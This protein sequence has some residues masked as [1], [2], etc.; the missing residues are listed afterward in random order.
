M[1]GTSVA[2]NQK[3]KRALLAY[4]AL[5]Q[6]LSTPGVGIADAL[7]PF[8]AEACA[9][10][11]GQLFDAEK[12]SGAVAARF[13]FKIPRLAA[14]GLTELLFKHKLLELVSST[15]S[16]AVY[17]HRRRS[18]AED[19]Q[20]SAVTE[21]QIDGVLLEF[22]KFC[23]NDER[24]KG[25]ARESLDAAFL[26]RLLNVDSM[27][28]L[29]RKEGGIAVKKSAS[30]I[31]LDP[32]KNQDSAQTSKEEL[33]LDYMM[34]QFLLDLQ[35]KNGAVFE[36]VSDIAFANMAAEAIACFCEPSDEQSS[37]D[38]LTVYL[39][40]PLLLDMLGVNSEY[41]EYGKELLATIKSSGA[42]PAI[43]DHCVLEAEA[44]VTARLGY[45][46]SGV[47][48]N[49]IKWGTSAQP[50]LLSALAGNVGKR[51]Y[52]RLGIEVHRD[53]DTGLLHRR[54]PTA[55]G[56]I[57]TEIRSRMQHWRNVDAQ[58]HDRKSIWSLLAIRDT[59]VPCPKICDSKWI[60]VTRNTALVSI[61]NDS[62]ATWLSDTTKHSAVH[63]QKWSPI[64]MSDKQFA[65]YIWAREGGGIS[66]IPKARLLANCSAAVRPRADV[67]AKAYNLVL[68]MNG[69][70]EA[71]DLAALFEDRE[72]AKSLMRATGGDPEDVT[73]ERLPYIIDQVKLAAGEFAAERAREEAALEMLAKEEAHRAEVERVRLESEALIKLREREKLEV[74]ERSDRERKDA[75][76]KLLQEQQ[77]RENLA[78]INRELLS[79]RAQREN[80]EKRRI[81]DVLREGFHFGLSCY[82]RMRWLIVAFYGALVVYAAWAA[83]DSP[84]TAFIITTLL[85][86]GGFWFVPNILH[87][88]LQKVAYR[89]L[90]RFVSLKD[91]TIQ[92]PPSRPN[93][94]DAGW[95]ALDESIGTHEN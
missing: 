63:V 65:G 7:V 50:D 16:S 40:S 52:E 58:D 88:P 80:A 36:L 53:P 54:S 18:Q 21:A 25:L 35:A 59:T 43:L 10:L 81:N 23:Q 22:A 42:V 33:H 4:C 15:G 51:A 12:F 17:R 70:D 72:G 24:L 90:E 11:E 92:I 46:R 61:A 31:V 62:W 95:E 55:V 93:F 19:Q 3:P 1:K 49:A 48:T 14:L 83:A 20:V 39:D 9:E 91:R 86:V 32:L 79:E 45:L 85:S 8:L 71:D 56:S 87:K 82:R 89:E 57:E 37:L 5:A 67:K 75:E 84:W 6:K 13:G 30:T 27:R 47:N 44:A 68:E 78:S 60:F 77:E 69:K 74:E 28:L 2:A 76:A 66:S 73:A 94:E 38:G 41:T 64:S 34:S 26:A 29:G